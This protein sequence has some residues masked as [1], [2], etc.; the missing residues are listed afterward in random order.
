[1]RS[2]I[3]ALSIL[4]FVACSQSQRKQDEFS[5]IEMGMV[6]SEVLEVA[7]PP[8]WSDRK[9][10]MDRWFYYM[11]PEDR[12]TERVVYFKDGKVFLKGLKKQPLLTA[13]EAEELKK[14]RQKK[15]TTEFKPRYNEAQLRKAVKKEVD[16]KSKK[17]KMELI[18]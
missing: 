12:Q 4:S 5:K 1:M 8:H 6:K 10:E 15:S 16:K 13:E 3:F 9:Q 7:G 17:H 18:E 2:L 14:P 11:K